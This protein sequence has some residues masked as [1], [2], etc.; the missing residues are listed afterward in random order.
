M[1]LEEFWQV[2]DAAKETAGSDTDARVGVL[3]LLLSDLA[4]EELQLFQNHYDSR[5]ALPTAGTYGLRHTSSMVDVQMTDFD[6]SVTGL[7]PRD[8]RFLKGH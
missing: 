6:T 3:R 2:I 1:N 7:Y 5:F 4:A 8:A